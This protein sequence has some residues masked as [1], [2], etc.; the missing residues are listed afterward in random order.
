MRRAATPFFMLLAVLLVAHPLNAQI[1]TTD[2]RTAEQKWTRSA[3]MLNFAWAGMVAHGKSVGQTPAEVGAW[4]GEFFGASWGEPGSRTIS[5]F[6]Q[7]M[8]RN[9]HIWPNMEIEI[10]TESDSEVTGRM[11]VPYAPFFGED[12]EAYG[13]TLQ[14]F[15]AVLFGTNEGIAHY[16]GFD[17]THE[18]DGDWIQFRVSAR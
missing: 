15:Q 14:E 9:Y 8:V 18:V 4:I 16:L 1:E 11:N 10:L 12:G 6:V 17:M 7:G 3:V 2:T 13:V 5:S